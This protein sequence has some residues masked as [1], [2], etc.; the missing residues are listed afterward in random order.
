MYRLIK[1]TIFYK[2]KYLDYLKEWKEEPIIP[3][4]SDLRGRRFETLLKE[5]YQLE[6]EVPVPRG[7][8]P[9][10]SYLVIDESEEIIGFV[11]IRHYL[12]IVLLNARGHIIFGVKPSKRSEATSKEILRISVEEAKQIGIKHLKLVCQKTN[13]GIC[14][15]IEDLGGKLESEGYNDIDHYEI[16]R[17]LIELE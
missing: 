6:H 1:P 16:Q 11:N 4:V 13:L 5:I 8:F 9:D 15:L 17:Y 7:Y 12:N 3:V 10:A 2:K 14:E